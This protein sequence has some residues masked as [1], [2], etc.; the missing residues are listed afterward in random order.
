MIDVAPSFRALATT[1][2]NLEDGHPV[3][4]LFRHQLESG[5]VLLRHPRREQHFEKT[6]IAPIHAEHLAVAGRDCPA[7]GH[8]GA[9]GTVE[10]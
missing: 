10:T 3:W 4:V 2:Y 7:L 1:L 8:L 6:R 5:T 9:S